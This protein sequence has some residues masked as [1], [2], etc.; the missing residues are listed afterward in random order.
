M[1]SL[2]LVFS[3]LV[4]FIDFV[5]QVSPNKCTVIELGLKIPIVHC[6][7]QTKMNY[8]LL[9][10]VVEKNFIHGRYVL[11]ILI[12]LMKLWDDYTWKGDG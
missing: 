8:K 12:I 2:C 6:H 1:S 10:L 4:Y 11:F 3:H 7:K 9:R 5:I